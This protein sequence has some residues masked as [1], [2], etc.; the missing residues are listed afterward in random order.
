MLAKERSKTVEKRGRYDATKMARRNVALLNFWGCF[1]AGMVRKK[2]DLIPCFSVYGATVHLCASRLIGR[3]DDHETY[4]F[5]VVRRKESI[6][7]VQ[8]SIFKA[9]NDN[10][11]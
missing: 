6:F 1:V 7:G 2:L 9:H 5:K 3:S 11:E 4:P 10:Q 8:F